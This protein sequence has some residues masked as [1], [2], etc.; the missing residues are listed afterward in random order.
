MG[1]IRSRKESIEYQIGY[2]E[3][4]QDAMQKGLEQLVKLYDMRTTTQYIVMKED[5]E[6]N[7][8]LESIKITD[9]Y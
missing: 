4:Y 2:R 8:I 6:L 9:L 7:E 3:G 5:T 1:S